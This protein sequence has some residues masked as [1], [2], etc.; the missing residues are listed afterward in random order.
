ML[1]HLI[2]KD[3]LIAKTHILI[4]LILIGVMPLIYARL[5]PNMSGFFPFLYMVIVGEIVLLQSVSQLEA[6]NPKAAALLCTT[7]YVRNTIVKA[8]YVFFILIFTYCYVMH[9]VITL[10]VNKT[11]L[12]DANSILMVLLISVIIYGTYMPIEFKYGV[13]KAKFI[14]ITTILVISLGPMLL[15]NLLPY[16]TIDFLLLPTIPPGIMNI[17]L[18]LVSIAVFAV[19]MMVSLKIFSKK[20]L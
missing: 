9:T 19:S 1:F 12:L 16:I 20:E 4:I 17:V 3:F 10:L 14:F 8:K 13:I 7:P 15:S 11:N 5:E 2:K 6:K 18:A